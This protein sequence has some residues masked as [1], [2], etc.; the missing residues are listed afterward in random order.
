MPSFSLETY[1]AW[2]NYHLTLGTSPKRG[3]PPAMTIEHLR[4]F[5]CA[6]LEI[7]EPIEKMRK[8]AATVAHALKKTEQDRKSRWR[9]RPDKEIAAGIVGR[10]WSFSP[11]IGTPF[12]QIMAEGLAWT[13]K[14]P[15]DA[16][17][18]DADGTNLCLCGGGTRLRELVSWAE[19]NGKSFKTSGTHMGPTVAG[20]FGTGSHGSRL[21]FGGFQNLIKGI[22]IIAGDNRQVWVQRES[23]PVLNSAT[24]RSLTTEYL[25]QE[26]EPGE[27]PTIK[28]EKVECCE[29]PNDV[30]F[31]NALI[32]LGCMGV[33]NAVALELADIE[34]FNVWALKKKITPTWLKLISDGRF[35]TI[36]DELGF[37]NEVPQ[38]YE[39]T[40]DPK[41]PF[42]K[43]AAH[44]VY[45]LAE[46]QASL[47][48][49]IG[50]RPVPADAI[51]LFAQD[52]LHALTKGEEIANWSEDKS[53]SSDFASKTTDEALRF[54]L[55]GSGTLLDAYLTTGAFKEPGKG[56][57]PILAGASWGQIH[58]D[59]ISGG[60]PGALY[61]A[62]YAVELKNLKKAIEVMSN[63]VKH[64]SPSFI[65]TVRFVHNSDSK[66]AFTRFKDCAVIEIDGLSRHICEQTIYYGRQNN[67]QGGQF[68][69]HIEAA[70]DLLAS[71]VERG[72]EAVKSALAA[73]DIDFS[74]HWAKLA[75]VNSKGEL[76]AEKIK[77][78]FGEEVINSWQDTRGKILKEK[79]GLV[80]FRNKAAEGYG[81]LPNL[82]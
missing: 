12:A 18:E 68:S 16:L 33:V 50:E 65:F 35:Q 27:P 64:L 72:A 58:A 13:A 46:P 6:D 59:E 34:R 38:F 15:E 17:H 56:A 47:V 14:I 60:I 67:R 66:M 69:I 20:C 19:S 8:S 61:N 25:Y 28:Y 3:S 49:P 5:H 74:M 21:K 62:S 45:F 57:T 81:L 26:R 55:E 37:E 71:T 77:R 53:Q 41:D 36:S 24:V 32:H 80:F 63:A 9:E 30:D 51:T 11:L 52:K 78:D 70:L 22:H 75:N 79:Q 42:G 7:E 44:L 23:D 54:L 2:S 73:A 39:L 31:E 82:G 40:I 1:A 43:P 48:K 76:D 29:I 4:R 10:G